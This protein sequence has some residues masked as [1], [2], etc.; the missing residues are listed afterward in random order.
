MHTFLKKCIAGLIT[1]AFFVTPFSFSYETQSMTTT[2]AEAN[3]GETLASGA[4][5]C[6]LM[7]WIASLLGSVG[8][9]VPVEWSSG[10]WKDQVFDC[11]VYALGNA[12][13][14][15]ISNNIVAWIQGGFDGN[16]AFLQNLGKYKSR[17]IEDMAGDFIET[18]LAFLCSPFKLDVQL[19]LHNLYVPLEGG[20]RGPLGCSLLDITENVD[21]FI[22][23]N[24]RAGGWP[25][26]FTLVTENNPYQ[27]YNDAKIELDARITEEIGNKEKFLEFG[28][29]FL[30]FEK[31]V[32]D[33]F[34]VPNP[35]DPNN[36]DY[37]PR[38]E[39]QVFTPGSFIE[40]QANVKLDSQG[41]RLEMADE[42][43]EI[44]NALMTYLIQDVLL[45]NEGLAGYNRDDFT[46]EIPTIDYE[47][48]LPNA[49]DVDGEPGT[50]FIQETYLQNGNQFVV[51][52]V[53]DPGKDRKFGLPTD[54]HYR[55]AVIEFDFF[56]SEFD[57][58]DPHNFHM[59]QVLRNVGGNR[60][61]PDP[62]W[63]IAI[64]PNFTLLDA[65]P[66]IP[67][68]TRLKRT[69]NWQENTWYSFDMSYDATIDVARLTVTERGQGSPIV[70]MTAN[71]L[72][73]LFPQDGGMS[74][75]L[76]GENLNENVKRME[77]SIYENVSVVLEP[78]NPIC[79]TGGPGGPGGGSFGGG[80]SN[81]GSGS[82]G[83]GSGGSGGGSGG[84][85]VLDPDQT[86]DPSP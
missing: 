59:I 79:N 47:S 63:Y 10:T 69:T 53:G 30:S 54:G 70:N 46:H 29:G 13:I 48:Y 73:S 18:D 15:E 1:V 16:P 78:G 14:E 7:G 26:W 28:S 83:G 45:G 61:E 76:S 33:W 22:S 20:E 52:S 64:G 12:I 71:N 72:Y 17:V 24:F 2:Y 86:L 11:I 51:G 56:L 3:V 68:D 65:G 44:A 27:A 85:G 5:A 36:P 4:A 42:I 35:D 58:E 34:K 66:R 41:R 84:G 31:E 37:E 9:S 75:I 57:V 8:V 60:P 40:N 49:C 43:N 25:A 6:A 74:L 55:R 32:C 80:G 50:A 23:G 67:G 81:G 77:G 38:C 19:A 21:N 39:N 62:G 82:S